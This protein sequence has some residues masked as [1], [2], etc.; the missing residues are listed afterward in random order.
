MLRFAK[1]VLAFAFVVSAATAASATPIAIMIGD[2]DGFGF[3]A[4]VVPDG[5]PLSNINLP[6]DRRSAAEAAA[7]NG[8]EQ[9]DFYSANFNPLPQIFDVLFPLSGPLTSGTFTVDMGGFQAT[10]FGQVAVSFNGVAQPNLFNFED[11][12]FAT[13]VR[14]FVLSPAAIANANLAGAFSVEISRNN[15]GDAIAFDYFRLDGDVADTAVPEPASLLLVGS[16]LFG[17]VRRYRNRR[18]TR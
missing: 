1:A 13:A 15:S 6:E 3:G 16:G 17:I 7:T 2:N 4:G 10:T 5:A 18:A 11:G 12:A 14:S 8:A 9:T